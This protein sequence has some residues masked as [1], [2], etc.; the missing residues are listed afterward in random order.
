MTTLGLTG[1]LLEIAQVAGE[2]AAALIAGARGGRSVYIPARAT[3]EHW[4]VETVGR[5]AADKIC[6]HFAVDDKRGQRGPR[7][8]RVDIPLATGGAYATLRRAVAKRLHD[9][10]GTGK[11]S[12]AQASQVGVTQRTVHRHRRIHRGENKSRGGRQGKLF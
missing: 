6:A 11:S 2:P 12:A 10:D 9:L 3:D 5:A 8:T 4:L 7:G 1:V